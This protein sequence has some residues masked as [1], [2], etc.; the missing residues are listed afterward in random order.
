MKTL[1][2]FSKHRLTKDGYAYLA[3]WQG[4][5]DTIHFERILEKQQL[6]HFVSLRYVADPVNP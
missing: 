2:E 5:V 4:I 3:I 1:S 6:V